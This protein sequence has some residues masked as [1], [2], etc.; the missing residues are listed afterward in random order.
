MRTLWRPAFHDPSCVTDA[1][2][3][4]KYAHASVPGAYQEVLLHKAYRSSVCE[5]CIPGAGGQNGSAAGQYGTWRDGDPA[6]ASV[7]VAFGVPAANKDGASS[8]TRCVLTMLGPM[9]LY[10][11]HVL[12]IQP[13]QFASRFSV[14]AQKLI[15]LGVNGLRVTMLGSGDEQGHHPCGQGGNGSPAE[16]IRRKS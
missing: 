3:E 2:V 9:S 8:R 14:S 6:A 1:S 5:L 16:R 10:L 11:F 15:D 4:T 12:F 7:P 13:S